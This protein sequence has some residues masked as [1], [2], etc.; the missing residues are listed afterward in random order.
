MDI[1]GVLLLSGASVLGD[2]VVGH[3]DYSYT[4]R[5][6]RARNVELSCE[7]PVDLPGLYRA[8]EE[9]FA[10]RRSNNRTTNWARYH[11]YPQSGSITFHRLATGSGEVWEPELTTIAHRVEPYIYRAYEGLEEDVPAVACRTRYTVH[12]GRAR[13]ICTSCTPDL[14]SDRFGEEIADAIEKWQFTRRRGDDSR[15]TTI[16]FVFVEDG[17]VTLDAPPEVSCAE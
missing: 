8:A 12:N 2:D 9:Q 16:E 11:S 6:G 17:P 14:A 4:W 15:E 3:C 1:F 5:N 13:D 7:A 10:N